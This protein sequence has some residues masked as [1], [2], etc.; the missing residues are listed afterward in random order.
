MKLQCLENAPSLNLFTQYG[1][2]Y[3]VIGR[4]RHHQAL[5]VGPNLLETGWTTHDC[6]TLDASDFHWLAE[7]IRA[8]GPDVAL[9]GT[10][11]KQH[12][13][14]PALQA[15]LLTQGVA[16][17]IMSTPAACRTYNLLATE[18]RKALVALLG[19]GASEFAKS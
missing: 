3:V 18:G 14:P 9:L 15:P 10:G 12:F 4:E 8:F 6:A 7:R 17:E 11:A 5:I 2:D 19:A 1:E 13:F 16:L